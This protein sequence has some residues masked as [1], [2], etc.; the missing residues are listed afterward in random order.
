M[1]WEKYWRAT[2]KRCIWRVEAAIKTEAYLDEGTPTK[3]PVLPDLTK[4]FK[5]VIPANCLNE[6]AMREIALHVTVANWQTAGSL[7]KKPG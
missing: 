2:D 5:T 4:K 7:V 3:S 6:A 1:D